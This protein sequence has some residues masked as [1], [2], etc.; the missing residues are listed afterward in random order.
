M[1]VSHRLLDGLD[2]RDALLD[3]ERDAE[4]LD[5]ERAD[6][7]ADPERLPLDRRAPVRPVAT[8]DDELRPARGL[9]NALLI[10]GVAY[11]LAAIVIA[12][13]VL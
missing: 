6:Q 7:Y 8:F 11:L 9:V 2:A 5:A 4:L 1:S 3:E 13:V 12:V 10:V